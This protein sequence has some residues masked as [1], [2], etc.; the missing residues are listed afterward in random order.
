MLC[1]MIN[2]WDNY[3]YVFLKVVQI[4]IVKKFINGLYVS[5][6]KVLKRNL[7]L[8]VRFLFS[9]DEDVQALQKAF[10][11]DNTL[12]KYIHSC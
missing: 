2:L 1:R 10:F 11:I 12:S 9:S 7:K 5:L 6:T 3:E 4:S 8:F